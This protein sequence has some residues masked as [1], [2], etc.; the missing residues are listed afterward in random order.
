MISGYARYRDGGL[1]ADEGERMETRARARREHERGRGP[2]RH[3]APKSIWDALDPVAR[4]VLEE[5]RAIRGPDVIVRRPAERGGGAHDGG[6]AA[7][8]LDEDAN[9]RLV[10]RDDEAVERVLL[11]K[12]LIAEARNEAQTGEDGLYTVGARYHR[13]DFLSRLH[14]R[15]Q[16]RT[17]PG[18]RC[19]LAVAPHA[20]RAS[21]PRQSVV[22]GIEQHI[23]LETPRAQRGRSERS[24]GL[25]GR[26]HGLELQLDFLFEAGRRHLRTM[27][28]ELR[29]TSNELKA[30]G[31]PIPVAFSPSRL[32]SM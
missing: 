3:D 22:V 28:Y 9:R 20:Q 10:N 2:D 12:L 7:F 32:W 16:D 14:Q 19:A 25:A 5:E 26:L 13:F 27:N 21:L 4:C 30:T 29:A 23:V 11:A 18:D 31:K 15:W 8:E 24:N 6:F 17:L 1:G